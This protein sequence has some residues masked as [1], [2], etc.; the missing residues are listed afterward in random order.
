MDAQEQ[1]QQSGRAAR[2]FEAPFFSEHTACRMC[3][4]LLRP[5]QGFVKGH[6]SAQDARG[7][8]IGAK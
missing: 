6:P 3:Q 1:P 2:F 7:F 8:V 5:T 4:A